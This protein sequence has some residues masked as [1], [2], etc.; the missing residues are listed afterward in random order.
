MRFL[1]IQWRIFRTLLSPILSTL[2]YKSRHGTNNQ[3]ASYPY[4]RRRDRGKSTDSH[5]S[6]TSHSRS[7]GTR[8]RITG[9]G[10]PDDTGN[11]SVLRVPDPWQ[12]GFGSD[13]RSSGRSDHTATRPRRPSVPWNP[14]PPLLDANVAPDAP[15]ANLM[16]RR[17]QAALV[18]EGIKRDDRRWKHRRPEPREQTWRWSRM[19]K[20]R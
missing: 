15:V 5:R 2:S 18:H 7:G 1:P 10:P 3:R 11:R 17:T 19:R 4:A 8:G 20:P 16:G 12:R 9:D 13:D 6:S 14:I